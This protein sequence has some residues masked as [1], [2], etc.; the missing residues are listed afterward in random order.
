M[1]P[2]RS[3]HFSVTNKPSSLGTLARAKPT[4]FNNGDTVKIK[5]KVSR[6]KGEN[7]L[8]LNVAAAQ[9]NSLTAKRCCI[10]QPPSSYSSSTIFVSY[11]PKLFTSVS[12]PRKTKQTNGRLA[13]K[14]QAYDSSKND[15]TN[16]GSNDSKPP[17][18]TLVFLSLEKQS[19]SLIT[20][21]SVSFSV[22]FVRAEQFCT[23][24]A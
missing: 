3:F 23:M 20:W 6:K 18:G 19:F 1:E 8:F 14:I 7:I 15:S 16:N 17:N 24:F 2:N 5:S 12:F 13:L 4:L 21:F 9:M 11:K 22:N 10:Y